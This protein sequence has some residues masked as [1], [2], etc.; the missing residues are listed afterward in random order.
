MRF[1][2]Q[3]LPSVVP[4]RSSGRS[5][6]SATAQVPSYLSI[7]GGVTNLAQYNAS[8]TGDTGDFDSAFDRVQNAYGSPGV[9]TTQMGVE[10]TALDVV[11]FNV[12]AVPEPET[13]AM[14][15]A[16]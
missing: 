15:L 5:T 4:P 14:L 9:S 6:C 11:G 8:G 12:T 13:Y 16:G 3:C 10:I 2:A 1:W 7:D